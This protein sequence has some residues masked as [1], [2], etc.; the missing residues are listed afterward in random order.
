MGGNRNGPVPKRSE[1]R[2]RRN[3]DTP[4]EKVQAIGPVMVPEL[5]I[6]D[7]HPMVVDFYDSLKESAQSKYYEPSDWQFA[8]WTCFYMD[9]LIKSSRPSAVMLQTINTALSGLLVTE[10]ERRRVRMEV[11]REQTNAEVANI[12]DYFKQR[13]AAQ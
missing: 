6:P 2:I 7:P 4:I 8:R 13:F 10:G 12:A 1:E 3:V 9:D 5:G 11:E